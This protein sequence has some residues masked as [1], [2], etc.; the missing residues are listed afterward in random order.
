MKEKYI[1]LRKEIKGVAFGLSMLAA[2]ATIGSVATN[3]YRDVKLTQHYEIQNEFE[4]AE[5]NEPLKDMYVFNKYSRE[6]IETA[7]QKEGTVRVIPGIHSFP[8]EDELNKYV[9][10]E[11][12]S[13]DN[14][15]ASEETNVNEN[16]K[17][18]IK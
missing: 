2:G 11:K 6:T 1:E 14:V 9:Y 16:P 4:E 8:V 10:V 12:I 18:K 15:M 13:I 5:N 17:V 3:A 7:Y